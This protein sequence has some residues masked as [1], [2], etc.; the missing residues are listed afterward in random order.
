MNERVLIQPRELAAHLEDD[1]WII[2]DCRHSLSEPDQG[3][4]FYQKHHLPG[5]RFAHLDRDLSAPLTPGR[6]RHPLP[7][8]SSFTAWLGRQGVTRDHTVVAYDD[9][10]NTYSARLWWMLRHLLGHKSVYL[11]DGGLPAW[12]KEGLPHTGEKPAISPATYVGEYDESQLV[13]LEEMEKLVRQG[14]SVL[15]DVRGRTRYLGK[16]EPLDPVAGHIP[17]AINLP[18]LENLHPD[19]HFLPVEKLQENFARLPDDP[20]KLVVYC[21][22]GVTACHGLVALTLAGRK[23][24]RVYAGSWSEW[25][26]SPARPVETKENR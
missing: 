19:G 21:G 25:C 10:G 6:G 23:P 17:G 4:K 3:E 22:S 18:F 7:S 1:S 24:G 5:A 9:T 16:E 11:L 26:A 2:F 15:V 13:K 20:E 14:A 12:E 8:A